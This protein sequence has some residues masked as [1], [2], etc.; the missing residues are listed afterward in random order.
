V[1]AS[2]NGTT[3]EGW[4]SYARNI[5]QAGADALELN[6]YF[7]ATDARETSEAAEHR[8]L[9]VV[10][11]VKQAVKIPVAVKLSPFFSSVAHVA[12]G[13]DHLGA[14]GLVLFNRF[15]QPDIDVEALEAVPSLHL[16][17][18]SELLLRLRWLAI[19]SGKVRASLAVSGGVHTA[20][21][22]IKAI[23]TG[24]SAVQMVSALLNHGPEYV[25]V[26]RDAIV[27]WMEEHEYESLEQMRGSM[28]L[29]RSPDPAA[30]E[31]ANYMRI[32]QSYR[33]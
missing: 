1:I 14:D 25:K 11:V 6:V 4:L 31:R 13:L 5:E 10:K 16:S 8:V 19:L 9:D 28:S 24:A 18:S 27:K 20:T 3:A 23:M 33:I 15:Y 29:E 21:D 26:V 22:A 17:D 2:L 32:L 30:F 7:L 12:A